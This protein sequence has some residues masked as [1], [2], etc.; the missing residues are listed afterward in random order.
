IIFAKVGAAIFLER[1][2]LAKNFLID[3]NM[4]AYLSNQKTNIMFLKQFLD[5]IKLSKFVQV[6]ALPSYNSS[7]LAIIP[8]SLPCLEEQTKIANFLS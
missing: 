5:N 2:R 7:D 1:K 8:I 6:G 4:M 3:N